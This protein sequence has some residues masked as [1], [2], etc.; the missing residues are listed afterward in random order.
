MS[1][2]NWNPYFQHPSE[3]Q[4]KNILRLVTSKLEIGEVLE[5]KPSA[6]NLIGKVQTAQHMQIPGKRGHRGHKILTLFSHTLPHTSL[7]P[8][9][10][11]ISFIVTISPFL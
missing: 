4:G 2:F 3:A 11:T 1:E 7:H 8:H 6:M 9:P 5:T 10:S